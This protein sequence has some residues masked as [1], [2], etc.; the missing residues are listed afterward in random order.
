MSPMLRSDPAHVAYLLRW[1]R[2]H[3]QVDNTQPRDLDDLL[4]R[5]AETLDRTVPSYW[6]V[7]AVAQ[8]LALI[9]LAILDTLR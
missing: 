8:S 3:W 2:H 1:S 7:F 6:R 4:E 5:A 9:G